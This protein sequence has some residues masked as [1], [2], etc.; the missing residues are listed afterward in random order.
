MD[1]KCKNGI[2]IGM[3]TVQVHR[4]KSLVV[5]CPRKWIYGIPGKP[6]LFS[7][8]VYTFPE[9]HGISCTEFRRIPGK[10]NFTK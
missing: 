10:T 1:K 8:L 5:G 7:E 4:V 6:E 2:Q 9:F 3:Y